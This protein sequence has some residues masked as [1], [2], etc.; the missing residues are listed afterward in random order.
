MSPSAPSQ[1]GTP[2]LPLPGRQFQRFVFVFHVAFLGAM[3]LLLY[4]RWKRPGLVWSGT[5]AWL[6]LL[7][8]VQVFLYIRFFAWP[9]PEAVQ[10]ERWAFYF[11]VSFA[12][13]FITW[14]LEPRY[15]WMMLGYLG[16]LLGAVPPRFSIP[17]AAA[18]FVLYLPAK[19]GWAG[20]ARLGLGEWLSYAAMAVVWSALGLFLHKLV[21]TSAERAKLIQQLEAAQKELELAR[22]RDTEL[23]ALRERERLARELHDSLGHGL[24]TLTVQLEAA[25]RLYAVDPVRAAALM[26]EMKQLTR[27]SMEQLRRSL[28]G[29][30][31]PG[32]G[33]RSLRLALETLCTDIS[34][35]TGVKA[36]CEVGEAIEQLPP[37]LAEVLWRVAQEGLANA[38]R[39]AKASSVGVTLQIVADGSKAAGSRQVWLKVSDDGVGLAAESEGKPGHY[40]LRGAR[41]RVEGLGGTFLV[42]SAQPRGTVLEARLP[43]L[44]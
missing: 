15:E 11:P 16:Q 14:R 6:A 21:T 23:A 19:V 44:S 10:R 12:L 26:Q 17:G 37:A 39:H 22:Q 35:R 24:V 7:L 20:L 41:E 38:E 25:Q 31:A 40:G 30:R 29:L 43:L 36:G 9:G 42:T 27:T 1:P 5:E 4:A 32:L 8:L 2:Q 13:W 18:V 3:V 34:S 33:D 28:A